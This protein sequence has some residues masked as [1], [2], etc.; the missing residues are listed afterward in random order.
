MITNEMLNT[1]MQLPIELKI[2]MSRKR[3]KQWI[4]KFGVNGCY[5][6]FSGGKDSTVLKH[7]V[8]SVVKS[9]YMLRSVIPSVFINTGLEFPEIVEF[10]RTQENVI[11]IKPKMPFNEVIKK[12]GYPV[13]SKEQS[14]FLSEIQ[15]T[16]S[17]KLMDIRLNGNKYGRGKVSD[18]WK[19]LI[20]APFKISHKC[21]DVMKKNPA[22]Y[23][24]K[25]TGRKPFLGTMV[26]ESQLRRQKYI[27]NG[28]NAFDAKRPN[29]APLSFW[30]ENDIWEYIR[31]YNISY[32]K[33]YDM[34]YNRTGC[35]FCMY[36]CHLAKEENNFQRMQKTHPKQYNYCINKLGCGKVLDYINIPY[37]NKQ[38]ELF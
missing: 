3:I 33:I 29:S 36:G 37:E 20:D 22:K 15:N 28:C 32:S 1:R 14:Q 10:V 30:T 38:L 12:Y 2:A 13:I 6:S 34:G 18:K 17:E 8:E 25:E 27:K 23:Y 31:K 26:Q 21:C 9:D 5:I 16:K 4:N 24:E 35:M 11:E 7:M 19:F